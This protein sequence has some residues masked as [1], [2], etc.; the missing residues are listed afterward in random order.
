MLS[1]AS[2]YSRQALV[3]GTKEQKKLERARVVIVGIGALGSVTAELLTRAGIGHLSIIDRDVVEMTNLQRQLLYTEKDIGKPKAQA[4]AARLRH[5]N[6]SL[7]IQPLVMDLN[8]QNV[9]AL[10]SK[11]DLILDG[12]DNLSTRFLINEYA[13]KTGMS[14]IYAGAIQD[15]GTIMVI[16]PKTPCFRCIFEETNQIE[17]C[18]TVGV[19]NTITTTI[20][21]LQAQEALTILTE[22]RTGNGTEQRLLHISLRPLHIASIKTKKDVHCPVCQ[23][24]YSSLEGKQEPKVIQ[25]ECSEIYSFFRDDISIPALRKK[26]EKIAPKK[27]PVKGTDD[28]LFFQNMSIFANGKVLVKATSL[29]HAKATIAK[30]L[31]M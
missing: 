28:Y 16:T 14:W 24:E 18:D 26:L 2:R 6:T 13:R 25:H 31:G 27:A 29:H 17:T 5:I 19:L 20:A 4:A 1:D 12:T 8:F 9:H 30:Y 21:A 10:L 15:H 11:H 22:K 23:G 3:L 7:R